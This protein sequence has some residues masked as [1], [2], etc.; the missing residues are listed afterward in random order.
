MKA[1]AKQRSAITSIALKSV[2]SLVIFKITAIAFGPAGVTLLAHFQN[3]IGIITHLSRE[4]ISRGLNRILQTAQVSRQTKEQFILS[5]FTYSTVLQLLSLGLVFLFRSFFLQHFTLHLAAQSFYLIFGISM[6]IYGICIFLSSIIYTLG[7][8]KFYLGI[9]LAGAFFL[10]LA[11][12]WGARQPYLDYLLLAYAIGQAA[13]LLII[14]VGAYR[15]RIISKNNSG[16]SGESFSRLS[17][18]LLMALSV[19]LFTK[20]A[21]FIVRDFAIVTFGLHYTGLWQAVVKIS[22]TYMD[23]FIATVGSVYYP[24][25]SA[26]IFNSNHLRKYL[27]DMLSIVI[28]FSV[29][30]LTILYFVREPVT[31]IIFSEEFDNAIHLFKFQL[32]G[33]FFCIISYLLTY[34]IA[35]QA[36]TS[37]FILL[38]AGSALF[39]I[40]LVV[41]LSQWHGIEAIPLAHAIRFGLFLVLLIILNKRML[42]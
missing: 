2:S 11:V 16:M 34:V 37:L 3:L 40:S 42:F 4:G 25:V 9:N 35:A 41:L 31:M 14:I 36:R 17:E 8:L 7:K 6:L 1:S 30:G 5:G 12:L 38:Q 20:L 13:N 21:D 32:I 18:F 23:I 19:L 29:I 15:F 27:K 10:L 33:D 28:P 24:K 26:L 22:D 39:Y